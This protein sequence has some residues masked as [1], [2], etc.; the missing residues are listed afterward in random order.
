[1]TM[2]IFGEPDG[3]IFGSFLANERTQASVIAEQGDQSIASIA[4]E[5]L[6]LTG[7]GEQGEYNTDTL[8][9]SDATMEIIGEDLVAL[10][11]GL[12]EFLEQDVESDIAPEDALPYFNQVLSILGLDKKGWEA[13]A[14]NG[15]ACEIKGRL[16]QLRVGMKRGDFTLQTIKGVTLHEGLHAFREQNMTEQG[17]AMKQIAL[18]GNVAFEEGALT[19]VEQM[20]TGERRIAGLAYYMSLGL[21]LNLDNGSDKRR[22]FRQT[23]EIMWRRSLLQSHANGEPVMEGDILKAKGAAFQTVIRTTR[24]NSLDARDISYFEGGRK[25][26]RWFNEIAV[27]PEE[28][29]RSKLRVMLSAKFDPTNPIQ[30]AFFDE[31]SQTN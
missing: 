10:F 2:E 4:R 29:R 28:E 15:R 7:E 5:F 26:T 22:D 12:Q 8:E 14:S 18:P 30:E 6:E 24:G 19:S 27:L 31:T 23:H 25:A 1:M 17:S 11:P 3:Q 9:L 13:V 20:V 21:Q 16:K